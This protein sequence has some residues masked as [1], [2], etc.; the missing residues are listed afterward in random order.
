MTY[1]YS[2]MPDSGTANSRY[3]R[4]GPVSNAQL[5]KFSGAGMS[6]G[7]PFGAPAVTQATIVR[8]SLSDNDRLLANGHIAGPQTTEA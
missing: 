7:L 6:L 8:M 2:T 3:A 4:L 5:D 1:W